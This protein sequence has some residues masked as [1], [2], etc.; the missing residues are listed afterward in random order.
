MNDRRPARRDPA[1]HYRRFYVS[2]IVASTVARRQRTGC[3]TL[4]PAHQRSENNDVP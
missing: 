4:T 1:R 2:V 3:H